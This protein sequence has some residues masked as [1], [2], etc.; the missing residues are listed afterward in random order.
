M[1]TRYGNEYTQNDIEELKAE[2]ARRNAE[3]DA[4][5]AELQKRST[6]ILSGLQSKYGFSEKGATR[7]LALIQQMPN[8]M[9]EHAIFS[10]RFATE[11]MKQAAI[12][13]YEYYWK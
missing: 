12:R 3:A 5:Y 4:E 9:G 1:Y 7:T 13:A 6:V 10:T 11:E 2:Q 8:M